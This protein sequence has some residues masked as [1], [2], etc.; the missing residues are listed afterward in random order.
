VALAPVDESSSVTD[1]TGIFT[2]VGEKVPWPAVAEALVAKPS[3]ERAA[4]IDTARR[5][6][7]AEGAFASRAP[8]GKGAQSA[9]VHGISAQGVTWQVTP[10][11]R[12]E[13]SFSP[14]RGDNQRDHGIRTHVA[15]LTR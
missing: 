5:I 12:E 2:L 1:C 11:S 10:V 13:T 9:K 4:R 3:V 6:T 14:A 8:P 7:H 15:P